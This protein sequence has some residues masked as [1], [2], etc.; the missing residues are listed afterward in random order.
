MLKL[1]DESFGF[2]RPRASKSWTVMKL[3]LGIPGQV[4]LDERRRETVKTGGHCRVG[5][6]NSPP[7]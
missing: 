5:G 2:W 3:I 4:L 7:G 6:E 1:S